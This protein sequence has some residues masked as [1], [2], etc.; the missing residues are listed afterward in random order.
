MLKIDEQFKKII[1]AKR[2]HVLFTNR[3]K[4]YNKKYSICSAQE[5]L[6]LVIRLSPA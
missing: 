4:G 5:S 1:R 6:S 2:Q 3:N